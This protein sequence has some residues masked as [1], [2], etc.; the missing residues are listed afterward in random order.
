MMCSVFAVKTAS[1][2]AGGGSAALTSGASSGRSTARIGDLLR[3]Q[4]SEKGLFMGLAPPVDRGARLYNCTFHPG[5]S[6][7]APPHR[8]QVQ[9]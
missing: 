7:G 1:Q 6:Q 3:S 8:G 5:P 4:A 9:T 2:A